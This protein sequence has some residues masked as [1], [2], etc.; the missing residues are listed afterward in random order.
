[1][2]DTNAHNISEQNNVDNLHNTL[3]EPK[4]GIQALQFLMFVTG[5][6]MQFFIL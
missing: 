5:K 6:T 4:Q 1:M 3:A 2:N